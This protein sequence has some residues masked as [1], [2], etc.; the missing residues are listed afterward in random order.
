MR[1]YNWES[2]SYCEGW[3]IKNTKINMSEGI[4]GRESCKIKFLHGLYYFLL[5]KTVHLKLY[6]KGI[7]NLLQSKINHIWQRS[8]W[9]T[10]EVK[11]NIY[12][13]IY[14]QNIW[15]WKRTGTGSKAHNFNHSTMLLHQQMP[16]GKWNNI[17]TN[18][19]VT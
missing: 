3:E 9:L 1:S 12:M 16:L 11:Q 19:M 8:K 18:E 5:T 7:M 15:F 4:T 10:P 14:K 13:N 2:K 6:V 17:Y